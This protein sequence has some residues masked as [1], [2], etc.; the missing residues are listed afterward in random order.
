MWKPSKWVIYT[1]LLG[2]ALQRFAR[3]TLPAEAS[4]AFGLDFEI[5]GPFD[6]EGCLGD[7]LSLIVTWTGVQP[8][9]I[10][11]YKDGVAI[12]GAHAFTLTQP[13]AGVYHAE[14]FGDS[15][16]LISQSAEVLVHVI[17]MEIDPVAQ[18]LGVNSPQIE[19]GII[20]TRPDA[21]LTWRAIPPTD[22]EQQGNRLILNPPP[23]DT[24]NIEATLADPQ[25]RTDTVYAT[26]L[27]P[28][29][30]IYRDVDGDGCNTIADLHE[31][32]PLWHSEM[33]DDPNNNRFFEVS[34][35]LYINT[36]DPLPC[37]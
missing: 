37:L 28:S 13:D 11:W 8:N 35:L 32:L 33:I 31:M 19:V 6:T 25:G 24:T 30:P 9:A 3:E 1:V 14:V 34:D 26:V 2:S 18:A 12:D 20:C 10:N 17:K 23:I 27:V 21:V 15:G 16:T 22:M 5:S 7:S 4:Q 36:S 29:N